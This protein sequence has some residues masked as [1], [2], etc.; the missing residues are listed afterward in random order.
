MKTKNNKAGCNGGK[1]YY[2]GIY[3]D[4]YEE[5]EFFW[6][7][8]EASHAGLVKGFRYHPESFNIFERASVPVRKELK[9]KCKVVERFLLHPHEYTPDFI[10]TVRERFR[11]LDH[12]LTAMDNLTYYIDVKGGFSIYNNEREFSINQKAMYH[13]YGVFVNKV[14]P[15][16]FFQRT[17]CPA[18]AAT[19]KTGQ[20]RKHYKD[21]PNIRRVLLK[22][23][24]A[25]PAIDFVDPESITEP[26]DLFSEQSGIDVD[27][28]F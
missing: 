25:C 5:R 1:P 3:F 24:V 10:F 17:Y 22:N 14:I 15:R 13:F 19:T 11:I 20:P 26:P 8:E 23:T 9:T 28:S 27:F 16:D 18:M 7:L 12:G 21:M 2:K 4:S 6:W